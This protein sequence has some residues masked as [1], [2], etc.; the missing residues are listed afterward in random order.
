[1]YMTCQLVVPLPSYHSLICYLYLKSPHVT[2]PPV[3]VP[4]VA[5][6][7]YELYSTGISF[8]AGIHFVPLIML[9]YIGAC[10][11]ETRLPNGGCN[12]VS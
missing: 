10:L 2:I 1:M 9:E 11:Y 8:F 7:E 4:V 6:Y 5:S 3:L 12:A